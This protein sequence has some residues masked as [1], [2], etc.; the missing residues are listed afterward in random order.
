[1]MTTPAQQAGRADTVFAAFQE[2][3]DD[4]HE[5]DRSVRKQLLEALIDIMVETGADQALTKGVLVIADEVAS[6]LA[7][8]IYG[9]EA[10]ERSR[11]LAEAVKAEA[12]N[13]FTA[14]VQQ[15]QTGT[16]PTR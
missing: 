16:T 15:S 14:R 4:S 6:K 12:Q 7:E 13:S 9:K 5:M 8:E 1:M 2:Y 10:V 3:M 11:A